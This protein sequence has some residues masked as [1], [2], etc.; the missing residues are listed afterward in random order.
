MSF[1]KV[2]GCNSLTVPTLILC[3]IMFVPTEAQTPLFDS[4][5]LVQLRIEAP[6]RRMMSEE[7]GR[8]PASMVFADT[9]GDTIHLEISPRGKS[10]LHAGICDFPGL[11]LFFPDGAAGS[12][13]EGQGAVPVVTHCKDRDSYE[14]LALLEYLAYRTYNVLADL[15]L[16]VRLAR[17]EYFDSERDRS[18]AERMG[19]FLENYDVLASR[20][21]WVRLTVPVVPPHEYDA[22][23]RALFEVFQYFIG[24][25]DW[26]FAYAPPGE[27]ECCHNAVPI[28]NH[29]GPVFPIPFDFD[30]AGLV[31]APYA[32]VDPSLRIRTVRNRLFRGICGPPEHLNAALGIFESY[33]PEI[34][35][36]FE[37]AEFLSDR[38]RSRS[39]RYVE[40]FY[41]T[42]MDDRK[43]ERELLSKCRQP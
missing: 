16:R 43:V 21:G 17:I 26:S 3:S 15:S 30:Q 42:I 23:Q 34:Q 27:T 7:E 20:S 2:V 41:D 38:S 14:Q 5:D 40:E 28:G 37:E 18:V 31:D 11:M 4:A 1:S 36:L 12:A 19:F 13:F 32:T 33:Q 24:N 39:L 35:A 10:R 29:A 25:T 8:F 9:P 6:F 22:E